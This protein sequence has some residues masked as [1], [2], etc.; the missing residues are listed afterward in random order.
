MP[1]LSPLMIMKWI[2][3]LEPLGKQMPKPPSISGTRASFLWPE[4]GMEFLPFAVD[5]QTAPVSGSRSHNVKRSNITAGHRMK[6]A[7]YSD[8]DARR[9]AA[10]C[11]NAGACW[12]GM[13]GTRIYVFSD[14]CTDGRSWIWAGPRPEDKGSGRVIRG[15]SRAGTGWLR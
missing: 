1:T 9:D 3:E 15:E 4:P 10:T 11:A 7:R 6:D 2:V 13:K 14:A 5:R 12:G 8:S